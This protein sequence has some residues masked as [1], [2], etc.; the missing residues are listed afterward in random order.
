MGDGTGGGGYYETQLLEYFSSFPDCIDRVKELYPK[1]NGATF[2]VSCTYSCSCYAE[3]GMT[4]WL[5][6]EYDIEHY[7]SCLFKTG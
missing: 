4:S 1:A 3:F 2:E 5:T 6:D 7:Q